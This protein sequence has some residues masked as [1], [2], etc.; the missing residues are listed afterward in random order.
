VRDILTS[1][2]AAVKDKLRRGSKTSSESSDGNPTHG[3]E[4][5]KPDAVVYIFVEDGEATANVQFGETGMPLELFMKALVRLAKTMALEDY[6]EDE[7]N[8]FLRGAIGE[9]VDGKVHDDKYMH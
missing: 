8:A 6:P 7:I 1:I 5:T 3:T 9:H 2:V 4:L